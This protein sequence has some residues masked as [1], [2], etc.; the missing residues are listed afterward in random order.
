MRESVGFCISQTN[1]W[2]RIGYAKAF[3]QNAV[4]VPLQR[5]AGQRAKL[6]GAHGLQL[7]WRRLGGNAILLF[8]QLGFFLRLASRLEAHGHNPGQRLVQARSLL[9]LA[10]LGFLLTCAQATTVAPAMASQIRFVSS[11]C[12]KEEKMSNEEKTNNAKKNAVSPLQPHLLGHV[13]FERLK[14]TGLQFGKLLLRGE[15]RAAIG[16]DAGDGLRSRLAAADKG[17]QFNARRRCRWWCR[18][19][20]ASRMGC[21]RRC[22]TGRRCCR[23]RCQRLWRSSQLRLA[24]NDGSI[25][26]AELCEFCGKVREKKQSG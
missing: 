17:R 23:R 10:Q 8:Q 3:A 9:K 25:F 26:G 16:H 2:V 13:I 20:P 11:L 15:R 22:C 6:L 5:C 12:R 4:G 14:C 21:I 19:L 18:R 24:Q 1:L 7:L